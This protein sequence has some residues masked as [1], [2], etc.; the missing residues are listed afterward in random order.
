[1][2]TRGVAAGKGA[3]MA[4]VASVAEGAP[5]QS[6]DG[7]HPFAGLSYEELRQLGLTDAQARVVLCYLRRRS[8]EGRGAA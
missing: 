7:W 4:G 8:A 1:M 6:G 2:S 5:A 3:A